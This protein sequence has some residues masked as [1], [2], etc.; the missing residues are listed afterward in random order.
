MSLCQC[1]SH[2]ILSVECLNEKKGREKKGEENGKS[3]VPLHTTV[4]AKIF[5]IKNGKANKQAKC[6]QTNESVSRCARE[7]CIGFGATL[8]NEG[9]SI[10]FL[11]KIL[12]NIQ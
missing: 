8:R 9:R 3:N 10:F 1:V 5:F 6:R 4:A 2:G 7:V 12:C 11:K